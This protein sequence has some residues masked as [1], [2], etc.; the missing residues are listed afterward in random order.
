ME[1]GN[2]EHLQRQV[3]NL[4]RWL[5]VLVGA[6]VLLLLVF[7]VAP[8]ETAFAEKNLNVLRTR[9]I[10]VV[11]EQNRERVLVGAPIPTVPG[12]KRQDPATGIIVL[13][14]NGADRVAVGFELDP[15]VQ[16]KVVKR[17]SP[18]AGITV[19]DLD[20][21]ERGGFGVLDNGRVVLG[22][23]YE[24]RE[25]VTLFVR[26]E[27]YAG[28]AVSGERGKGGSARLVTDNKTGEVRLRISDTNGQERVA[29]VVDQ[30]APKLLV[31]HPQAKQ[32]VDLLQQV[33]Q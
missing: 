27:G 14:E 8:R 10:V 21:N 33:K 26:P 23:D 18:G 6:Y 9:G 24:N 15:Q 2:V 11:D 5:K 16:G 32:S 22:L 4:G 30:T 29:I 25:A 7:L 3:K 28:L 31:S 20:G 19:H 17:I 1:A 13:G 12:R